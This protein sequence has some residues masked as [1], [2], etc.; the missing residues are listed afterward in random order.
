MLKDGWVE[1]VRKLKNN[2]PNLNLHPLDAI[3]Y[4]QIMRFLN[5]EITIRELENK[6]NTKTR[7]FAIKQIKWFKKESIDL[8]IKMNSKLSVGRISNNIVDK[9]MISLA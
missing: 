2:Y 6:I 5:G 7:Q 3:G 1:E 9:I 4:S 8:T